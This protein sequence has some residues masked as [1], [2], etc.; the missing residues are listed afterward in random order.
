MRVLALSQVY[1]GEVE[2]RYIDGYRFDLISQETLED[3]IIGCSCDVEDIPIKYAT[4]DIE[5]MHIEHRPSGRIALIVT[6][7]EE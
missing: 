3:T 6:L 1:K 7:K 5:S 4:R 2:I